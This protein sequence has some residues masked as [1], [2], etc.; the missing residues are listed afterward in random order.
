MIEEIESILLKRAPSLA[1]KFNDLLLESGVSSDDYDSNYFYV[2]EELAYQV[3]DS[4]P[5]ITSKN[6]PIGITNV[7]Y[8]IDL[9]HCKAF[10]IPIDKVFN[11]NQ[12]KGESTYE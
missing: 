3:G 6:L 2:H 8:T 4:F 10:I 12:S 1:V 9:S 7:S 11:S 5:R